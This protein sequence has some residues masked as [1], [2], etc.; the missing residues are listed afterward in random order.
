LEKN[1]EN[2]FGKMFCKFCFYSKILLAAVLKPFKS[3]FLSTKVFQGFCFWE[4]FYFSLE[5]KNLRKNGIFY[6]EN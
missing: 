1:S 3:F 4:R 5:N 6:G 2:S